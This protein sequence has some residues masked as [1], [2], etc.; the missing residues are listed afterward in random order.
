MG[1]EINGHEYAR[2]GELVIRRKDATQPWGDATDEAP[3][4][5]FEEEI[6]Q[7]AITSGRLEPKRVTP[8]GQFFSGSSV[9][10]LVKSNPT[11]DETAAKL[12]L[13]PM[14]LREELNS[15]TPTTTERIPDEEFDQRMTGLGLDP[16][17]ARRR[18]RGDFEDPAPGRPQL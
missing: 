14:R 11:I 16:V 18:F 13:T 7:K 15:H 6:L 12:G 9:G 17:E 8:S 10:V 5:F 4:E 1:F 3:P 2:F